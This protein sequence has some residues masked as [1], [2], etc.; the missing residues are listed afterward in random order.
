[1][2]DVKVTPDLV[3]KELC[4][5]NSQKAAGP[6]DIKPIVLK[7]CARSLAAPLSVLFRK[8]LDEGRLPE[9][10]KT[11]KITPIFKKGSRRLA[12]NYR[13]V[14]LTSQVCKLLERIVRAQI[15]D[16]LELNNLFSEHQHGFTS[17]KSCQSNLLES[18]EEWSEALDND[19]DLDIIFLDFKKAFDTVPHERLIK[20]L[21]S[22]GIVSKISDWIGDFLRGRTQ[23]VCVG[24]GLSEW[25]QVKSGVP[26]GSV[27]G[28]MLFLLYVNELPELVKSGIKLFADDTKIYRTIKG[29]E[30]TQALQDDLDV[31][32]R[33]SEDWMLDFN[34]DKCKVMHCGRR[35]QGATYTLTQDG[36]VH[37]LKTTDQEKD[38]GVLVENTLKPTLHCHQSA[39]K[40][41]A[42][43]RRIRKAFVDFDSS[44]FRMLYTT[45]VRPHLEYC[46]QAV[47]PYMVQDF[48]VLEKIQR[49]ATKLVR[50]LKNVPYEDR[51]KRL[52]IYDMKRRLLRG[53]L[54]LVFK[55]MRGMT[56]LDFNKFFEENAGE[57]T[58]GHNKK[59]K[60]KRA[61][62]KPRAMTFSRRTIQHW[63]SLPQDVIQ[64]ETVDS[65]KNRLDQ[66]WENDH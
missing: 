2:S 56:R 33:W 9:D 7:S 50:G 20:K 34:I 39:N 54:I 15:T 51:L 12:C 3:Y 58:R 29:E 60:V 43:L 42:A 55:I 45:Y 14:S 61:R 25:G 49:R 27:L 41:A 38:L 62:H 16:H 4:N 53:D 40:A 35:N 32:S 59:L 21:K 64:A 8:T 10:W 63:N 23:Q 26:Q 1:M 47:G 18:L 52:K 31:L 46:M 28:P 65:F 57:R 37:Q 66:H 44:S 6:D 48:K 30:D 22:Y 11:A 24:D 17:K 19:L 36:L 5:L 13:P